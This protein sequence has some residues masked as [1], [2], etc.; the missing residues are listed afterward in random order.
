MTPRY[1]KKTFVATARSSLLAIGLAG[2]VGVA[3]AQ[4]AGARYAAVLKSA[5]ITARYNVQLEQQ[6]SSQQAEIAALE[7]QLAAMDATA[8]DVQPLLQRMFD[9]LEQFVRDDV[10][11]YADERAQR[12]ER[13]R[14][15]MLQVEAT[16]SEK[17]R[18]LMEAYQIEMGYGRTMD[19]YRQT[20]DG[21]EAELVRLGRVTLL[22]R[23]AD[24]RESG[25]WDNQQ[26]TWVADPDA[27]DGIEEAL[28][29]AKEESAADLIKVPIPAPQGGR[30]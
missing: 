30:S 5:D 23:T 21:R 25:Y 13:L 27:A 19:S 8:L 11:F 10:P 4:D 12:V 6:L 24:G 3:G 17:F 9:D 18:R 20:I 16:A 1:S 29:I 22:Y 7:Q 28:R 2:I 26:K 14:E 15:T